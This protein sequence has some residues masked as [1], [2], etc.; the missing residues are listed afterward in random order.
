MSTEKRSYL[1]WLLFSGSSWRCSALAIAVGMLIGL[2]PKENILVAF[3]ALLLVLIPGRLIY[4]ILSI[5]GFTLL[6]ITLDPVANTIGTKLLDTSAIQSLGSTL[7]TFPL[8]AWTML[9]N[10]VVL[11]QL[12]IGTLLFL[13]VYFLSA[14]CLQ[15]S[16][17]GSS[18]PKKRN[19]ATKKPLVEYDESEVEVL[20]ST[21]LDLTP[22]SSQCLTLFHVCF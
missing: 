5:V 22:Y 16:F 18:A 6:S 12:I 9:N 2:L 19:T 17:A 7:Y 14:Q 20:D 4:G 1:Y 11:G 15:L 13:P 3:F 21:T 10:T 8:G